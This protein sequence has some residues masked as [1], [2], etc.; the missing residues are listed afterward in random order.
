[1]HDN[2]TDK[3]EVPYLYHDISGNHEKW[4]PFSG[5]FYYVWRV[6]WI[7]ASFY[8]VCLIFKGFGNN[9]M[10]EYSIVFRNSFNICK[11]TDLSPIYLQVKTPSP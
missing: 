1:M 7:F 6:F 4:V 11:A 3:L 9:V 8:S 2:N 10:A 5:M